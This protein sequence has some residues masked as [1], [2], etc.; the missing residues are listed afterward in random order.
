MFQYNGL[1]RAL[2]DGVGPAIDEP[3]SVKLRVY[4]GKAECRHIGMPLETVSSCGCGSGAE[5]RGCDLH[6][7]CRR[8]GTADDVRLCGNCS[9]YDR[10]PEHVAANV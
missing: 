3:L 6:G 5:L 1:Y 7:K 10:A 9:D 2:W 4:R 8:F